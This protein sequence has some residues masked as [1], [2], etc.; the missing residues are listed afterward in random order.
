MAWPHRAEEWPDLEGARREILALAGAIGRTEPVELLVP[1]PWPEEKL[2]PGVRAVP[3]PYGDAWTR[4]T[5]PVVAFAAGEAVALAFT[6]DGWGGRYLMEGDDGLAR[7]LA[8]ARGLP[9]RQSALV[10]EG[11]GIELDGEG[12]LLLTR[13]S[14]LRSPRA[15]PAAPDVEAA[16][17][18]HLG[19]RK[20]LWVEGAL[21]NDHTDGHIDTL[22]RFVRPGEVVVMAPEP[23][24]ANG[25]MLS[26]LARQLDALVDARGRRL[27]VHQVPSPGAVRDAEGALLP[28][29][30][31]NYYL[32]N[33]QVLVPAYGVPNDEAA[34]EALAR[35]FPGRRVT[36]I[37]ARAI[38]GGGGAVHCVTHQIPRFP[39]KG[40]PT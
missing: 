1:D 4:D 14:W 13:D 35:L 19:V 23:G 38:L 31:V 10:G 22:A 3:A 28:A 25:A 6:F 18:A 15:N 5:A 30:Y 40:D 9:L 24:D 27:R 11:G 34:V 16:L 21:A 39:E 26:A 12:T 29:S 37:P 36:G 32:A 2:P 33:G 7:W 17:E 8:D 20:V